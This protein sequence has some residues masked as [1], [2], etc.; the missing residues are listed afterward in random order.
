[1]QNESNQAAQAYRER[2]QTADEAVVRQ[3]PADVNAA[4]LA[5]AKQG[6]RDDEAVVEAARARR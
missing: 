6:Q 3:N 2:R 4:A 1:M 5:Y